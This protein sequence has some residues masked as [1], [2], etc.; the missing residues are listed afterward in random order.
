[1]K[2]FVV[3]AVFVWFLCGFVGAWMMGD[4]QFRTIARGPISLVKAY[5]NAEPYSIGP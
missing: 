3:F 4:I 5:D 1:M 2:A